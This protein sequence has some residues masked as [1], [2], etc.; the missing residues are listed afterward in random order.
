MHSGELISAYLDGELSRAEELELVVHLEGC[1]ACRMDL[2]DVQ[3]ARSAV[4]SLPILDAPGWLWPA[5]A[6]RR[7]VVRKRPAAVMAAATAALLVMVIGLAT[8]LAPSPVLE[9]EY[10]DIAVTHGARVVQDGTPTSG[11]LAE[12]ATLIRGVGAE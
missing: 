8:W 1:V 4:R 7:Q 3:S 9:M 5:D 11:G 10:A 12:M 2:A 6:A